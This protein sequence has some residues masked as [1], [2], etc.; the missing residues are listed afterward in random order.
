VA[1]D[2][3]NVTIAGG[4]IAGLTAALRL[5][6]RG[7]K[8]TLYE[9]KDELG[10]DLASGLIFGKPRLRLRGI[11]A[12]PPEPELDVYPHMYQG[13]YVNFWNLLKASGV[14]VERKDDKLVRA[15]GF[16][17]FSS[18]HQLHQVRKDQSAKKDQS[19]RKDLSGRLSTL[20]YPYS[21][22]HI[23]GNLSSGMTDPAEMFAI[24]YAGIDLQ[25][26][27]KI[28]TVRLRDMSLTGYLNSRLY[29]SEAAVEAYEGFITTVWGLPAY[30]ISARDYRDY[31]SYCY[32]GGDEDCWFSAGPARETIFDPIAET[33]ETTTPKKPKVDIKLQTKVTN[34]ICTRDSPARVSEIEIE[35]T[36]YEDRKWVKKGR[37]TAKLKVENLV[38]AM[39]PEELA[40]VVRSGGKGKPIADILPDMRRLARVRSERMPM[41]LLAFKKKLDH[42]PC[43]PVALEGSELKLAF[44]DISQTRTDEAF[45][46]KF[47]NERTVLAVSCS[48]PSMLPGGEDEDASAM[49]DELKTYVPFEDHDVAKAEVRYRANTDAQLSLNAVG[50]EASRPCAH[51][52][53]IE[54]LFFAGDFCRN[55]FGITTVEA[56]VATG[57]AAADAVAKKRLGKDKGVAVERPNL[58][59]PSDFLA[60]RYAWMPVAYA[61]WAASKVSDLA[62]DGPGK[63]EGHI[64]RY[65][66]TPGQRPDPK[67]GA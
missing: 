44:T 30:L 21:L 35:E 67:P 48:E 15:D 16:T 62:K 38:L 11:A 63:P 56:A 2:A 37:T 46:E 32:G 52:P 64:L 9:L 49:A 19:A 14:T 42:I 33:L 59:P 20:T 24:G 39:P 6:E 40:T 18:F 22:Q 58:L 54:N 34:V 41:L 60:A 50:T 4:G 25:A 10:G 5:A 43:E 23:L 45:R 57:L 12:M 1:Q 47:P 55:D 28:P 3:P 66:L 13:W 29:M 51:Y 7:C 8:V 65:L 26:E 31:S 17:P 61:A 36:K 53:E 27:T